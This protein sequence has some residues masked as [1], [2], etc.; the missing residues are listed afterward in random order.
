MPCVNIILKSDFTNAWHALNITLEPTPKLVALP[1]A[2]PHPFSSFKIFPPPRIFSCLETR[3]EREKQTEE[4]EERD[5]IAREKALDYIRESGIHNS[6][7]L[8]SFCIQSLE[9]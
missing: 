2:P 7:E 6:S 3:R 4:T 9:V 8:A 1:Y 5:R